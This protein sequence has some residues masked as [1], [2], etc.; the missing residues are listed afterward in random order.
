M[1][2]K[3]ERLDI[4][5]HSS[6]VSFSFDSKITFIYGNIG[7]G[8]T[9]LLSLAIYCL[10]GDLVETP[11][12]KD[13]FLSAG[14][15][16]RLGTD[17]YLFRRE[18]KSARI[19]VSDEAGW[20]Y[21]I[22]KKKVSQFLYDKAGI[23]SI[24]YE[25]QGVD[26]PNQLTF[27]NYLW[28]SYLNQADIDSNFFYLGKDANE[29]YQTASLNAL[30][31]LL[32]KNSFVNEDEKR[33]LAEKRKRFKKYDH[34]RVALN[35]V[36]SEELMERMLEEY[37]HTDKASEKGKILGRAILNYNRFLGEHCELKR[38]ISD[39]ASHMPKGTEPEFE[40]NLH[41]LGEI[42]K[43]SL[44]SIG[45]PSISEADQIRYDERTLNPTI[46]NEYTGTE[47]S[48]DFLGSG[49]KK[50]L[51]KNASCLLFI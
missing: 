27:K 50:T 10:G 46:T 4:Y 3:I 29:F 19:F 44:I 36:I 26:T 23:R 8:K 31:S 33:L 35:Y 40:K 12:V 1:K 38:Q 14:L 9:T 11:A 45:F 5:T 17:R 22:D 43:K 2:V 15:S 21:S 51:F 48:F 6:T 39:I 49:G 34:G 47:Y 20:I 7:V 16:V 24:Y 13:Q 41:E 42:F 30:A 37:K 25:R 18:Y 32:G 28:Y